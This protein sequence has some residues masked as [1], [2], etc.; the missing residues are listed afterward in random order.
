MVVTHPK[1]LLANFRVMASEQHFFNE[2]GIFVSGVRVF[3]RNVDNFFGVQ[4][5]GALSDNV[6][7]AQIE[8]IFRNRPQ[9]E[10]QLVVVPTRAVSQRANY[11]GGHFT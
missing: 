4:P 6:Y 5:L 8:Q 9:Q 1:E 2:V 10:P 7:T 3:G 11:I